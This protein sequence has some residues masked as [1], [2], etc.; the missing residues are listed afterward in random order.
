MGFLGHFL[1]FLSI[2]IVFLA[3]SGGFFGHFLRII[4]KIKGFFG[5]LFLVNWQNSRFFLGVLIFIRFYWPILIDIRAIFEGFFGC[6]FLV[7]LN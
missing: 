4:G 1:W 5:A 2:F 6:F 3:F 7:F